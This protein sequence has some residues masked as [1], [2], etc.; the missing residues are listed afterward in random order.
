LAKV[1]V[2]TKD[3]DAGA[4]VSVE[5]SEVA[6]TTIEDVF[7]TENID[8]GDQS[9]HV[10]QEVTEQDM[11]YDTGDD[12]NASKEA[13]LVNDT[14]ELAPAVESGMK[15]GYE[16]LTF[17]VGDQEA[18]L[19]ND[20]TEPAPAVESGEEDAD[21]DVTF[22]VGDQSAHV[23]NRANEMAGK[24]PSKIPVHRVFLGRYKEHSVRR[25]IRAIAEGIR[26][27]ES[28]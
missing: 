21:E 17:N 7:V 28:W 9:T 3:D 8:V 25:I 10:V 15:N 20:T 5:S 16:D 2:H 19:V 22:S 14:T 4:D 11:K 24:R 26:T 1:L 12:V 23:Q 6:S 18:A 13:T 27:F